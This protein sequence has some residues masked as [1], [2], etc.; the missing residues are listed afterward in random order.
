MK[1][2]SL[3]EC[4]SLVAICITAGLSIRAEQPPRPVDPGVR[5]SDPTMGTAVDG[6]NREY[7]ANTR[8][9]FQEE[10]SIAG[11]LEPGAG[12]GPRFN[13]TS[14]GGCHAYPTPGGSSPKQNPQFKMAVAHGARN[15]IPD[16]LKADG[17]VLAVRVKTGVGLAEPGE[18]LPLFTVSGRSD[19]SSCVVV[20]P[21][22][23]NPSNL[24]FRIPTPLFGAGLIDNIPDAVLLANRAAHAADK[25]ALGVAGEPNTGSDGAIG[26]FGW[27]AQHRSLRAFAG[28]AYRTEMG[29]PNEVTGYKRESPSTACYKLYDATYDDPNYSVAYDSEE[30]SVFLFREFMR[31]L[32]PSAPVQAYAGATSESIRAG[33]SLFDRVGCALCH[34]PSLLTGN[35]SDLHA[36]NGRDAHLYSDLLLHHMGPKLADG[37]VQGRAGPDEFR[38]A[39]LWGIGQ[40]IFFLH[41]GRTTDLLIAIRDHAGEG[42]GFRSEAG[43]VIDLFNRLSPAEQQE[44]LNFLRSL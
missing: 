19:A 26:K 22:F 37:I 17:P 5:L 12:L 21:E 31:F 44:I 29:V 42:G 35:A 15:N 2:R 28:D 13:G 20:P 1:V 43:P 3:V 33:G 41:D 11:D 16:F 23:T 27:K 30:P 24:S 39:P 32:K 14:C 34:T 7:F 36:L 40:R 18:V 6:V 25:L 9:A 8:S 4:G 38:T 10:H